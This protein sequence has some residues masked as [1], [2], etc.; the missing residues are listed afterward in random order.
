V[1]FDMDIAKCDLSHGPGVFYT[2]TKMSESLGISTETLV[3]QL[4]TPVMIAHPDKTI[5]DPLIIKLNHLVLMSGSVLTTVVNSWACDI[6]TASVV[7]QISRVRASG[8]QTMDHIVHKLKEAAAVVG[9]E[10]TVDTIVCTPRGSPPQLSP[11]K[12]LMNFPARS[13]TGDGVWGIPCLGRLFRNLGWTQE[14]FP[15]PLAQY[16]NV[17]RGFLSSHTSAWHE[18]VS[19]LVLGV[20]HT[21]V[22]LLTQEIV[23]GHTNV[24]IS[25]REEVSVS[26]IAERYHT[27]EEDLMLETEFF[28]RDLRPRL[29]QSSFVASVLKVDYGLDPP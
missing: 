29:V 14:N 26:S 6:L 4:K 25:E 22:P 16:K 7:Q 3:N 15:D 24:I 5:E 19:Q 11:F 8:P 28:F 12:F 13:L 18:L 10:I 9:Y 21:Q 20:S 23:D 27:T 17:V 2:L 1:S